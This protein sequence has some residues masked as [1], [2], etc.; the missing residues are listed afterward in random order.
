M[1]KQWILLLALLLTM[2]LVVMGCG[3]DNGEDENG[4][5][6]VGENGEDNDEEEPV[7]DDND[8][9]EDDDE[10]DIDEAAEGDYPNGTYRGIFEDGGE[11]QV[12]IQFSV[13]DGNLHDVS[14]RHLYYDGTDY[15]DLEEGDALYGIYEQHLQV[16]EYFE[17]EPVS[18]ITDLYEPGD[19]VDDVDAASGATLRGNKILSAMVDGLNRGL[20]SP[21]GDYS[22]DLPDYQDGTYRGI[23][24]D[25]GDQQVSIQFSVEDGS[26]HDMS[27][28]HLYY[29][30]TDYRDLE[31][32]DALYGIYQQH[33]QIAEYFE[34]KDLNEITEL[35]NPGDFVD[36][37]DAASGATLRGNKVYSAIRDALN[38]GIYSPANGYSAE[39]LED[40]EDGR[41][42]GTYGDGGEQQVSVQFN[43]EDGNIQDLTFRHLYY[44]GED[45]RDVEEGDTLYGIYQQHLQIAEYLEG[46]PIETIYDLH[47]PGDFVEDVDV[48]SGATLRAN[49]VFSAIMN[50]LSRGIY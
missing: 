48:A 19:F 37:V 8:A 21:D 16:A 24:G 28:R 49:K 50:G 40:V 36:D 17:G 46:E 41:Y 34:G 32:G 45:Y 33:Q 26:I 23:Y 25:S 3:D 9:D 10:E 12:S 38:R 4:E 42:R 35:H 29:G 7:D 11:Q 5:E 44:S 6:V 15:G 31:E 30:G 13:Q 14:F 43:V 27:F 18:S 1:K 22:I 39:L 2:S 20:Y 47:N